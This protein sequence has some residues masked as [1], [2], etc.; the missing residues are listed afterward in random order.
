MDCPLPKAPRERGLQNGGFAEEDQ[1]R[2]QR[3]ERRNIVGHEHADHVVDGVY[4][5]IQ[6]T[7]D[8][9]L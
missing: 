6:A 7:V 5:L 4:A 2:H 3:D 8:G 1:Q 9:G